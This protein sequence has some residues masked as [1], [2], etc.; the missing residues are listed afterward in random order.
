MSRIAHTSGVGLR[1]W[2]TALLLLSHCSSSL[3]IAQAMSGT[4]GFLDHYD[5]PTPLIGANSVGNDYAPV[6][7]AQHQRL[8]ITTERTGRAEIW[9]VPFELRGSNA[10]PAQAFSTEGTFNA[11][12]RWRA[13]VAFGI[14]DE[15]VGVAFVSYDTQAWPTIVTVPT[16]ERALNEGHPIQ[17]IQRKGFD[18]QP[19]LSADGTRLVYVSDREGGEGGLDLWVCDRRSDLEWDEPVQ[20]SSKINSEGDE[21]TPFFLSNDSLI[22]ASN[23]YGGK[24]GFDLFLSVLRDGVWQDP[25]PLEWF[26]SEFNESDPAIAP[27][28][29]FIFAT[30]RP[31]GA[32]MLDLWSSR[33]K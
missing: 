20:L 19:A 27:D 5:V 11:S 15:A 13:Y 12:G 22:Y 30:D 2:I 26:N 17:S 1:V 31:G 4:E 24:G 10:M 7:Q 25:Q 8:L 3:V 9:Q 18:S 29:T 32:G 33:R 21:I 16:D 23:G 14:N 6:W 28:R